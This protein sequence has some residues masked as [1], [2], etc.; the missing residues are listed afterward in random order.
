MLAHL[1]KAAV[2]K[3]FTKKRMAV[4]FELG[5]CRRGRLRAD[6]FALSMS[7][8][9]TVVEVKSGTQDYKTDSKWKSYLKYADSFY[10][11][12]D[13]PTYEKLKSEIPKGIGVLV[14]DEV[15]VKTRVRHKVSVVQRTKV[16]EVD[17]D[18]KRELL[19]RMA[20][21]NSDF[22]RYMKNVR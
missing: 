1:I 4:T 6:V 11:A 12:F 20:F 17:E 2:Q 16:Q 3:Y 10:F 18:V 8:R 14:V 21:R 22:T 15:Q 5:L 7:G 9:A 13:R 19:I